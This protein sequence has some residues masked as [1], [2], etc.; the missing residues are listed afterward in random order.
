MEIILL[1]K[2]ENLGNLG[3]RVNVKSGYGR[4]FLIPQGKATEA[5]T[6]NLA[7]FEA[8]RAELEQRAAESLAAAQARSEKLADL[9]VTVAAKAGNEGRLFGS[10]GPADIAD[11]ASAAG[12]SLKKQEVRLQ[13]GS[14]RALGEYAVDVRLH[15]DI[16]T[17]IK[18][19]VVAE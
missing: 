9:V 13:Q 14:L 10:V 18:V 5:T 7:R 3:D 15:S 19:N 12:V 2:I 8:Q 4:N 16:S 17:Q 11:A 6:K 1:Q